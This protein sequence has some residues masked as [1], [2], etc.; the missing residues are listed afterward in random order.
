MTDSTRGR[1]RSAT[2]LRRLLL[3][4]LVA[5]AWSCGGGNGQSASAQSSTDPVGTAGAGDSDPGAG[6]PAV[7]T[8]ERISVVKVAGGLD[9]PWSLA[10]LPDGSAL[11]TEKAGRMR[12]VGMDGSIGGPIDGVPAVAAANQGGL[13]DLLLAPD[14]A[15]SGELTFC[16]AEPA[17]G[18]TARTAVARAR[19]DGTSLSDTRVIFRQTPAVPGGGHFGCR[20]VHGTDGMLY[21]SL[22]ER[23]LR[24]PA[25]DLGTTLG[26]VVRLAPDGSVP[27]GNPFAGVAG[28][29][30]EIFTYG[31]RNP[32]GMD[33]H[34]V[35]G[36]IWVA[37]H[38]PRGGDEINRL[39]AGAN[40]G[41]PR[42][43]TGREY[44]TGAPVGEGTEAPDV[45]PPLRHWVPVSVA[46][47]GMVFY[48]GDAVP[49]LKG[50]LL[51]GTLAARTLIR[52]TVSDDAV[53]DE[54]RLLQSLN[55]RIRDVAQGPD[56]HPYLI[57]D[58]GD[59]FR[60][61]PR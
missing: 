14:F 9:R 53:L 27:P 50:S 16:Y 35:T 59:L 20:L 6:S 42:I 57:T 36:E 41:W 29:L 12:R 30:P 15:T 43:T 5:T 56:G 49:A 25:L 46:P 3:V 47:A 54:E 31:H 39:V 44:S 18:S 40:Y 26:K 19:L 37:E 24:D 22:G 28:V 33:V 52:M 32:Q 1:F 60:I 8:E 13:L 23:Q 17:E 21:V 7:P 4:L 48:T 58:G 55:D 45:E 51:M 61:D 38:G 11:V 10:F 2:P 34:P